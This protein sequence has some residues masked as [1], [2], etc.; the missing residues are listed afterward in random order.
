MNGQISYI[1]NDEG[2]GGNKVVYVVNKNGA[3]L[4]KNF[5]SPFAAQKF[6]NRLK[7]S[8]VCTLVSCPIFN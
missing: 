8:R 1:G 3:M 6:V 7:R 5:D 4:V 2:V